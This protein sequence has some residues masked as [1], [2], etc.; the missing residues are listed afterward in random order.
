MRRGGPRKVLVA[1][2]SDIVLTMD[3]WLMQRLFLCSIIC[4]WEILARFIF[5]GH[6]IDSLFIYCWIGYGF[7]LNWVHIPSNN[8]WVVSQRGIPQKV[9]TL[10]SL[11]NYQMFI[12][13]SLWQMRERHPY[14][15]DFGFYFYFFFF[16]NNGTG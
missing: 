9:S 11:Y 7:H 10:I 14:N 5:M 8:G 6:R 15:V 2:R 12:L 16:S 3:Y 4:N 13:C 1:V